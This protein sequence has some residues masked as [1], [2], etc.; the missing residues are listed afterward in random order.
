MIPASI[1]KKSNSELNARAVA[2][3]RDCLSVESFESL[4]QDSIDY[5]LGITIKP[6]LTSSMRYSMT[7]SLLNSFDVNS[8]TVFKFESIIACLSN[9]SRQLECSG[10]GRALVNTH[11]M[12]N[13]FKHNVDQSS[14]E[15]IKNHIGILAKIPEEY[16]LSFCENI[17]NFLLNQNISSTSYKHVLSACESLWGDDIKMLHSFPLLLSNRNCPQYLIELAVAVSELFSVD[18]AQ[19]SSDDF[20]ASE[21]KRNL[22]KIASHLAKNPAISPNLA[23]RIYQIHCDH[24]NQGNSYSTYRDQ[25][26]FSSILKN[27]VLFDILNCSKSASPA[28]TLKDVIGSLKTERDVIA[29]YNSMEEQQRPL[30]ASRFIKFTPSITQSSVTMPYA[31]LISQDFYLDIM[32]DVA[33][34]DPEALTADYFRFQDFERLVERPET[35]SATHISAMLSVAAKSLYANIGIIE[36]FEDGFKYLC[37]T[38]KLPIT[39]ENPFLIIN[40][41]CVDPITFISNSAKAGERESLKEYLLSQFLQGKADSMMPT[42]SRAQRKNML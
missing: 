32:V 9:A 14:R 40:G 35:M 19:I 17:N 16:Q 42:E 24:K 31:D 28:K 10:I 26:A 5:A 41:S 29:V 13:T 21:E 34:A 1:Y 12:L 23:K 4:L 22:L 18:P 33:K 8:K 39:Q 30:F 38:G 15:R 27:P 6:G 25:Y 11:F 20:I 36:S 37:S 7:S 2:Y 3:G